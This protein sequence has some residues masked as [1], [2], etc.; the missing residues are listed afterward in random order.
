MIK[1]ASLILALWSSTLN[2]TSFSHGWWLTFLHRHHFG[3]LY[4][5]PTMVMRPPAESGACRNSFL[6]RG[7]AAAL[8]TTA[9]ASL[10]RAPF[11]L[12]IMPQ[13]QRDLKLQLMPIPLSSSSAE[14]L[15]S[16]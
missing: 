2:D 7:T 6:P 9:L 3:N 11:H 5:L 4:S 12:Y 13:T 8:D 1:K 15:F 16:S 14:M 10:I